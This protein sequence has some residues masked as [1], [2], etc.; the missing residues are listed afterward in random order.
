MLRIRQ[1]SR[2][3]KSL[4]RR[5][6]LTI[7]ALEDR[8]VLSS[9][10]TF[11]GLEFV[12]QGRFVEST[13]AAETDVRANGPVQVGVAPAKGAA[14]VPLVQ[15]ANG[16]SFREGDL[17]GHFTGSGELAAIVGRH[18]ITLAGPADREL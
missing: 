14:F 16:V 3:C 9:S 10:R 7:D 1:S 4:K 17:S 12:T 15:F 13:T 8:T 18:S 2:S 5:P 11:G 6:Q